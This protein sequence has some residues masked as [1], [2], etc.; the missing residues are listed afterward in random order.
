MAGLLLLTRCLLLIL[1]LLLMDY[2]LDCSID[3]RCHSLDWGGLLVGLLLLLPLV[4]CAK[5]STALD[6]ML[7]LE[8][9]WHAGLVGVVV[10]AIEAQCLFLSDLRDSAVVLE[11]LDLME[12]LLVLVPRYVDMP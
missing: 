4:W 5:V 1:C 2:C 9:H 8:L 3:Y 6:M 7:H 10:A 11:C 12:L